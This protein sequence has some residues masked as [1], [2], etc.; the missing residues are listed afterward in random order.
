MEER[1]PP[2]TL[3]Y[4]LGFIILAAGIALALKTLRFHGDDSVIKWPDRAGKKRILVTLFSLAIYIA[5]LSPLGMPISTA[6]FIAFLVWYL[7]R[8]HIFYAAMIG[9]LS[10]AVVLFLFIYLLELSIPAGPFVR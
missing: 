10:G 4:I 3:P 1:L 2:R 5:L 8:Y 7:G 6:L 9:V